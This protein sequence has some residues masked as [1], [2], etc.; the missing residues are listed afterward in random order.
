MIM[1]RSRF[2]LAAGFAALVAVGPAAWAAAPETAL[3]V[4]TAGDLADLCAASRSEPAGPERINF[5]HGYA[6]GAL[7]MER[8]RE[9]SVGKKRICM[10]NP[11]PTRA[12]TLDEFAKWTRAIPKHQALPATDGLFTFLA[13]R[14]PCK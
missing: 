12:A 14:F 1:Q 3:S 11:A 13:E 10:P 5:C 7:D 6:Q 8:K 4:R 9:A 2:V